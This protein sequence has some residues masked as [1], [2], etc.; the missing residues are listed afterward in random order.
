MTQFGVY[1][2]LVGSVFPVFFAFYMGAWCDL[3]GRKLLFYIYLTARIVE[4]MIV[5]A[6]AYFMMSAKEYLLLSSIP[7]ALAGGY[8]V[9]ILAINA[10]VADISP[11]ETLAFRY[12][13]LHLASSLGRAIAPPAGA[14]LF[15]TGGY[16]CVFTASLTGTCLGALYLVV[17]VASFKWTPKKSAVIL[18]NYVFLIH[19]L[20]L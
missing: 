20:Y 8:G 11:P 13:M 9:W 2:T 1:K 14:Q 7:Q 15:L 5:I 18:S 3:F 17:R 12:G 6:C 10:F 19:L 4:Q 16:V